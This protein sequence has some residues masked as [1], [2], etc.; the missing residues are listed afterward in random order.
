MGTWTIVWQTLEHCSGALLVGALFAGTD[1]LYGMM[2]PSSAVLWWIGEIDFV[3]AIIVPT[4]LAALFLNSFGRIVYDGL[5]A[6]WKGA[7]NVN[8]Q[9]ILA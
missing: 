1:Y 3:L 9:S 7:P 2:F 6:T 5:V 4:G 8:A